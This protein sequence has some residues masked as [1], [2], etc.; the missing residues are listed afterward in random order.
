VIA[1]D[2]NDPE[3]RRAVAAAR[4]AL[5]A[6]CGERYELDRDCALRC[7]KGVFTARFVIRE[8][9]PRLDDLPIVIDDAYIYD[10]L[11]ALREAETHEC[12]EFALRPGHRADS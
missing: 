2:P 10:A 12:F 3:Q 1:Y 7:L 4:A 9:K 6:E 8:L 11:P 5:D